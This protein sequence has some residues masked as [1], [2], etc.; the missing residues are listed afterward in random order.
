[1]AGALTGVTLG[2]CT[3]GSHPAA[4]TD[5]SA[6]RPLPMSATVSFRAH[7]KPL[8][9][10]V[11]AHPDDD[12]YFMNPDT[13]AGIERDVPVVSVYV[14]GGGSFG[15]NQAPGQPKPRHDVP[16][17]VSARQQGLRQAYA[18]MLGAPVFTRWRRAVLDLP[19]GGQAEVHSL[20][21]DGKRADLVFLNIDMH[22]RTPHG[23]VGMAGL[24]ATPGAEV[25]TVVV[26]GSAV[27]TSR[28]FR[29]QTLIDSLVRILDTY[30]PTLIRTLDPD[31]DIQVHD[32]RHPRGS[33]QIGFS[34]HIDHT[35][36]ALFTWSAMAQWVD[37]AAASGGAP[38]FLTDTYRGYYNQRWPH[39][40]PQDTIRM[41]AALID[42]YGG[43]PSW[44]C[45]DP[46]GCGDYSVG[47]GAA[48][49]SPKGWVR[50]THYRYPTAGP[51]VV[52]AADGRT[53]VYGVLSTRAARWTRTRDGAWSAPEDLGGGPL[54]PALGV[55]TGAD[56][57]DL[58][59][60]LRF[61]GLE[62]TGKG[63]TREIVVLD[64]VGAGPVPAPTW[65]SLGN[66]EPE[67]ARGRRV[68]PPT[69]VLGRDGRV[70]VFVR[71]AAKGLST[72][73]RDTAGGWSPWRSLSGGQVQEGLAAAL[74]AAGR[75]HVF[76]AG[77]GAVHEWAQDTPGGELRYR[78]V[79]A[80]A[81]PAEA[82]DAVTAA[83]GSL[84]LAY[85]LPDT[86]ELVV[87][88]LTTAG[89]RDRWT[90]AGRL[91]GAGF[92]PVA[93]LAGQRAAAGQE[94]VLAVRS[95]SGGALLVRDGRLSDP[96]E[97]PAAQILMNAGGSVHA[98]PAAAAEPAAASAAFAV[99][100]P[101]L[102]GG[103]RGDPVL[104]SFGLDGGPGTVAAA[105][106]AA[107]VRARLA[108]AHAG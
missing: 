60:A 91:G 26:P 25:R 90:P 58:V 89:G 11:L 13:V 100:R 86:A 10:Q 46:Q 8:V 20:G 67:P 53:T 22:T 43:G 106:R 80:I 17:Y 40:L 15:V 93:L 5:A 29:R 35:A 30:R 92:G 49:R 52:A 39:N 24:W 73:V 98:K 107:G 44:H 3:H 63:N 37:G 51:R 47:G 102:F 97:R 28:A 14:T 6:T 59:L 32:A 50:S 72:R 12:L 21:H 42:T 2:G 69:A 83:D 85:R 68:G 64:G 88:K 70:H 76:A 41:K 101:A 96:G 84:L 48:L 54:A 104:V 16:A 56:G 61:S 66:P 9:M 103:D 75:I 78:P 7:A 71:N 23:M 79:K 94:P 77:R 65:R 87:E 38:A 74:D 62:G 105:G 81:A 27:R 55:V 19:G 95:G 57:R 31:P 108:G 34:D 33:D 1:M 4:P 99:G 36:V 82:P 45:G 18:R